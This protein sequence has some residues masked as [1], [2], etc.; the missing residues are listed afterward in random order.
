MNRVTITVPG[1]ACE[2]QGWEDIAPELVDVVPKP[3]PYRFSQ[4]EVEEIAV[5]VRLDMNVMLVGPTGCGKTSLP[6]QL[7][8]ALRQPCVRF[9]MDGETRVSHIR[10]QQRPAARD[11]VLT[12]DF[13]E[14]AFAEAMR[15]GW[16]VVLDE[17]EAASPAVLFTLQRALEEGSRVLQLPETGETVEGHPDFR[18]FA[19]SNTIGYRARERAKHAGTNMMNSAFVDRFGMLIAVDYPD[20]AEELER[21]AVHVPQLMV[22]GDEVGGRH[23]GAQMVEGVCFTAEMLRKDTRFRTDFSTRRCIQWSRLIEQFPIPDYRAKGQLPFDVLRAA[24]LAV[25]RKLESPTDMKVAREIICRNFAYDEEP[26][27]EEPKK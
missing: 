6:I 23:V 1:T 18:L 27:A 10:G 8:A 20:R 19:T 21:I 25:L 17:V 9:N 22:A 26:A 12:L 14:G 15:R 24:E 11:G 5:A 4:R 2:M 13:Y 7:A 16:W 3:K